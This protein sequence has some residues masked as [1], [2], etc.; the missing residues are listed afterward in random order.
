M[1]SNL[2]CYL[3][4]FDYKNDAKSN[5]VKYDEILSSGKIGKIGLFN[6][7]C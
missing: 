3:T 7:N 5:Y 6:N 1:F 4:N 2:L